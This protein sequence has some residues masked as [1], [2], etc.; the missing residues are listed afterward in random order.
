MPLTGCRA[1]RT[2]KAARALLLAAFIDGCRFPGPPLHT[3][4]QPAQ[5]FHGAG[6]INPRLHWSGMDSNGEMSF[7]GTTDARRSEC[8]L[9]RGKAEVALRGCRGGF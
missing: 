2:K 1:A 9:R 6:N 7:T 5:R 3:N 4:R 8:P